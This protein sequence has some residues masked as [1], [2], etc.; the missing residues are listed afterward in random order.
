MPFCNQLS[1]FS[2]S[3]ILSSVGLRFMSFGLPIELRSDEPHEL[4]MPSELE[5]LLRSRLSSIWAMGLGSRFMC[6]SSIGISARGSQPTLSS[7][8]AGGVNGKLDELKSSPDAVG[9]RPDVEPW[10]EAHR[11]VDVFTLGD[12]RLVIPRLSNGGSW[13]GTLP[14]ARKRET[15]DGPDLREPWDARRRRRGDEEVAE[16]EVSPNWYILGFWNNAGCLPAALR[17]SGVAT[18]RE[19]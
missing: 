18:C 9:L 6:M 8:S 14:L 13:R 3:C 1:V 15:A 4:S 11:G 17:W 2:W 7:S 16:M 19:Q 12:G 5:L 10:N